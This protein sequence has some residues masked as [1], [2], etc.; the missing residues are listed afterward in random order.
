M[1]STLTA[2]VTEI[3]T[4]DTVIFNNTATNEQLEH[5]DNL[6]DSFDSLVESVDNSILVKYPE[7]DITGNDF[8]SLTID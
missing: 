3:R 2:L 5:Y 6:L 7:L 4:L 1:I 8:Q